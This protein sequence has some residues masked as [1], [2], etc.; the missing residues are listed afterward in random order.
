ML[1]I[2]DGK[3]FCEVHDCRT[4]NEGSDTPKKCCRSIEDCKIAILGQCEQ[5]M[6]HS[7]D[8]CNRLMRL[9]YAGQKGAKRHKHKQKRHYDKRYQWMRRLTGYDTKT[10][11]GRRDFTTSVI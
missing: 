1:V 7:S 5:T 3:Y 10:E 4:F 9:G 6:K 8:K 11:D 2:A